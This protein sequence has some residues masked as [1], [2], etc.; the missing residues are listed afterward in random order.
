M[1]IAEKLICTV[2]FGIFGIHA[3][4]AEEPSQWARIDNYYLGMPKEKAKA[5]GLKNGSEG[6]F[7]IVECEPQSPIKIGGIIAT[8][9]KIE[10]EGGK[11]STCVA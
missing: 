9:S 3:T 7:N 5:V 2:C 8:S 1:K 6:I 10:L 11:P 4:Q